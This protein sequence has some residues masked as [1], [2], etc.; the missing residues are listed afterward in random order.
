MENEELRRIALKLIKRGM[1]AVDPKKMV[2]RAVKRDGDI[3]YIMGEAYDLKGYDKILLFGIGKASVKMA[4]AFRDIEIDDGLILTNA[5]DEHSNRCP[6]DI[7][8]VSHPYP[9]IQN[10]EASKELI[11]KLHGVT[12]SLIIFLVSGGGSAM[13]SLPP[14]EI[15]LEDIREL[16]RSMVTSGMDIASINTVRKH[17]SKI[18]G[19]QFAEIC[20]DKGTLIGLLISD[21]V[22][23]DPSNI[24]SGPTHGDHTSY[25]D[26]ISTIKSW[27]L[28]DRIPKKVRMHLELGSE[29]RLEDTPES[30][31]AKNHIICNNM[32]ALEAM[33]E[34][35][36]DMDIK[37]VILTSQNT[38]EAKEVAKTV[39]VIAKEI[40]DTENPFEPPVALLMGG[41]MTVNLKGPLCE[42]AKGGPNR[43]FVLSAAI[44]LEGEDG[45]VVASVDSDGS[46]GTGKAGAIADGDSVRRCALDPKICLDEHRTQDFFDSIGDSI[47][48]EK[49]LN[50][51]DLSV[52]MIGL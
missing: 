8:I 3:L 49:G 14:D 44:S 41:E 4:S 7:R 28:W 23:D 12:N 22:G 35:G 38:G 20:R 5:V 27:D 21:V 9:E 18:K 6:V 52:I 30:V 29:G 46:D 32:D 36:E 10:L 50:I 1:D 25:N 43:E 51:N 15:S 24:A 26:A 40:R 47:D 2:E 34:M 39:T 16:N 13:F 48:L 45:I 11:S 42:D 31:V 33:K 37:T 19:G 17:V